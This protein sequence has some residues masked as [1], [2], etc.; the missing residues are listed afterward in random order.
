MRAGQSSG[1][2]GGCSGVGGNSFVQFFD[3]AWH[4]MAPA[5]KSFVHSAGS[6]AV[7]GTSRPCCLARRWARKAR[8]ARWV[9]MPAAVRSGS[10]CRGRGA[11]R[12]S[13][14][15]RPRAPSSVRAGEHAGLGAVGADLLPHRHGEGGDQLLLGRVHRP[16]VAAQVGQ[17]LRPL[18]RVLLGQE[19]EPARA[20]AV[21]NRVHGRAGFALGGAWGRACRAGGA[22]RGLRSWRRV[23]AVGDPC[24]PS[25]NRNNV[26]D[27]GGCSWR[28][29]RPHG[30]SGPWPAG[31]AHRHRCGAR[32]TWEPAEDCCTAC[33]H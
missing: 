26:Q 30:P 14:R 33:R 24:Q 10:R 28:C 17:M 16:Q 20:Q 6:A 31:H 1:S 22:R 3:S 4:G 19:R 12:L 32:A 21:P 23:R 8:C 25:R 9:A 18:G 29:F 2:A 27:G 13:P 7:A 15:S 11:L 5:V